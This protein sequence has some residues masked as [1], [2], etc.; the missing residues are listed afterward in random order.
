MQGDRG[1]TA[2]QE[3]SLVKIAYKAG[4]TLKRRRNDE[5]R[6]SEMRLVGMVNS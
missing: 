2:V 3:K 6:A 4:E 1:E 5:L